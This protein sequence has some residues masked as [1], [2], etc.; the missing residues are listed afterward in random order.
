MSRW[1]RAALLYH[2]LA[3]RVRVAITISDSTLRL[4]LFHLEKPYC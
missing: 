4:E 1:G 3:C 2:F